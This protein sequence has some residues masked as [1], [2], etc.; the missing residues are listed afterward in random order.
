SESYLYYLRVGNIHAHVRMRNI[1]GEIHHGYMCSSVCQCHP[2]DITSWMYKLSSP[3]TS[4][5]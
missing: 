3:G 5:S 2:K 1:F 4:T